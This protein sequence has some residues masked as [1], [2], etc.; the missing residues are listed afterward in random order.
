MSCEYQILRSLFPHFINVNCLF[1]F[2]VQVSILVPFPFK[3]SL[4]LHFPPWY[5]GN[6]SPYINW[7]QSP[8]TVKNYP[9]FIAM[10]DD[11]YYIAVQHYSSYLTKF[12][13]F[14]ILFSTFWKLTFVITLHHFPHYLSIFQC[15]IGFR[16]HFFR[17][18]L[19]YFLQ[20]FISLVTIHSIFL[21]LLTAIY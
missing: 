2:Y 7:L 15:S 20:L 9:A 4:L 6:P 18:L 3:Y 19:Q 8:W 16:C 1:W 5:S 21:Q 12:S 13:S 10:Y 14:L 17:R 11:Q